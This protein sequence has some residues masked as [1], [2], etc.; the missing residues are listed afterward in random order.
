MKYL[1][2]LTVGVLLRTMVF[3]QGCTTNYIDPNFQLQVTNPNCSPG[4]GS[5]LAVNQTGGLGPFSY[6][7]VETGT[8][9]S[10]GAFTGLSAGLY[11]VEMRDA[12]GTV[13][14]RQVTLVPW[15]FSF[16]YNVEKTDGCS[17]GQ[18]TF[19][20][21]PQNAG[22]TYGVVKNGDTI[23][24]NSPVIELKLYK[25][26]TLVVK[27]ACGNMH[28]QVWHAPADLLPY[29]SELQHRL[30]CDKLDIF[31]VY[32]GFTNPTVC[33]YSYPS[34][35][36][37]QCKSV[38]GYYEGGALT[39]FFDVPYGEYYVIVQDSCFRDSMYKPDMRSEGGS[40]LNP[41]NW[42]CTSFT[43]HVDGMEDTVCLYNAITNQLISCKGQDTTS[44]N[45]RTGTRWPSGAVWDSLPYGSYYAW[46][47]DPCMDST[48]RIDSTVRYP[49]DSYVVA[50]P[51]CSLNQTTIQS[52][53]SPEAKKPYSIKIYN[54]NGTLNTSVV[55]NYQD[56]YVGV[57]PD[58]LGGPLTIIN[59]DACNNSDTT[60]ALPSVTVFGKTVTV[61]DKCPGLSGSGGSGDVK[62]T[63]TAYSNALPT[64]QIVKKNGVDTTINFSF[65]SNSQFDFANLSTGVYIIRYTFTNCSNTI[66]YDTVEVKDY[67]YPTQ[68]PD[69]AI[70]CG[71][72]MFTFT[73][74]IVGGLT[75]YTFQIIENVP[76]WPSL[77]TPLQ[78]NPTFV[79]GN[80]Q[81][82]TSVKVRAI[83]KCGNSTIGDIAVV[84]INGCSTLKVDS[85]R[86]NPSIANRLA[87]AY[88]NPSR[89][90]FTISISQKKKS[91][92]RIQITNAAGTT[93]YEHLLFNVDKKELV[94]SERWAPGLYFI[95]VT[96]TVSGRVV[97]MKQVIQ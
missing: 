37:V 85:V 80:G 14:T 26:L 58:G 35:A 10:S 59:A 21:S 52:T 17:N 63:V 1:L 4:T 3:A 54:A 38:T 29:I 48:F 91:N 27:D 6:T 7:L 62:V 86:N 33:L 32:Y 47:Y 50:Y 61:L 78:S 18:V 22:F 71:G 36:L 41:Y 84:P 94:V 43:M 53:F 95:K 24:S 8:V 97:V 40:E 9:N 51:G 65:S 28:T 72:N 60:I 93:V 92:Y 73:F 82:Y 69:T 57:T 90:Q 67:V 23:W 31:P 16:Q 5:I 77:V 88:P 89:H 12:C 96:D 55:T 87:K 56:N 13:R 34:N 68:N 42:D 30:Q 49:F 75:P 20:T 15:S 79:V 64:P 70:Q 66:V 39:N 81:H 83:D 2:L 45:P 46:I 11:T 74:P 25:T 19:T 76:A 44:I